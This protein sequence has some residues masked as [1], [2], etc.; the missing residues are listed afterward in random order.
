MGDRLKKRR[1]ELGLRQK[2]LAASLKVNDRTICNWENDQ[3]VPAVR[4]LSRIVEFLG[5]AP[6]EGKQNIA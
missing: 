2:D 6:A 1:Y 3:T 4:Y 5:S